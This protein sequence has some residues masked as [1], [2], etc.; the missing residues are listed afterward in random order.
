MPVYSMTGYASASS[1]PASQGESGAAPAASVTVEL[2]SVNGRFLDLGFRMPEDLRGLEPALRELIGAAFKRGKIELRINTQRESESSWP[3]PQPEQLNRLSRLESTVQGWLPQARPLSVNEVLHWCKSGG[4]SEKLDEA[5]LEAA[6]AC[7][8]GLAEAREREGAK[9]VAVLME[10][11]AR[12]REL[13][14]QAEPLVPAVVQRQQQRF[15]ERWQ[16]ALASTGATQSVPQEQLQE[17]ALNEAAAYAIRI[18]VAEELARLRAHLDEISR[19]LKKG[20]EI[21]KRLDFLIQELHRE[22][23]TLGSKSAALELTNVS[24]EMKVAIEQMREQ[25]QNIE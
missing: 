7:V 21:G 16:E 18:D 4:A 19:L 1:Q 25:V 6:R 22:A 23:N 2:R 10:R 12:L 17:R 20:G 8:A 13:A 9:L 14:Q 11:I 15:L 3:Q 24:V 5:T